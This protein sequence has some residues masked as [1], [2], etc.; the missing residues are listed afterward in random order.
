MLLAALMSL[1]FGIQI[2]SWHA[3]DSG[4]SMIPPSQ[5]VRLT[6]DNKL[7]HHIHQVTH[8]SQHTATALTAA[9]MTIQYFQPNREKTASKDAFN[10]RHTIR[11]GHKQPSSWHAL[12]AAVLSVTTA[13]SQQTLQDNQSPVRG[14]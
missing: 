7:L 11:G 9:I 14:V 1:L 6:G 2:L 4:I 12:L 10:T 8:N 3:F 13:R 5:C